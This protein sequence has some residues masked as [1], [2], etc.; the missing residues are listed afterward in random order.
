[1]TPERYEKIGELYHAALELEPAERAAFLAEACGDDELRDEVTCLLASHERADTFIE[2][3]PD[4][5]A[6]GWQA[7]AALQPQSTF[8]HYKLSSLLGKGGM[9]VVWLAEDTRLGRRVAI[10][11][12]PHE[13]TADPE[14]VR[15]FA[16][17]ARSASSLNHPNIVTVHE[18]GEA[19]TESGTTHYIAIEY[20]EG[21]TLRQQMTRAPHQQISLSEALDLATQIAAALAAAHEAGIVHRDIKPENVMVRRDGIVKVLDFGLA[22]L[23]QPATSPIDTQLATLAALTDPG[24]LMGTPRYMSPE[25]ARAEAVDARTDIFSLGVIIYEMVTGRIPFSGENAGEALAAI[26]RDE[27]PPLAEYLPHAPL[28]LERIITKALRK[29]RTVRYQTAQ[30]LVTDLKALKQQIEFGTKPAQTR[31]A[32]RRVSMILAATAALVIFSIVGWF[33]FNRQPALHEKDTVLLTDFDNKTG[34][35]VFDGAL[36]QALAIELLRSPFLNLFPEPQVRQQLALMGRAPNERVTAEIAGEICVRS[37]LKALIAGSIAP[38]GSHYVITLE[39]INGQSGDSLARQQVEA[40]SREQVLRALAQA[41][42]QLR[43]KLGESLSSI[44]KSEQ[45][46]TIATTS[47]LEAFKAWSRGV[48]NSYSGRMMEAISF[49]RRA[50]ELDPEFAQAYSILATIY[51][52]TGRPG[53]AAEYAKKGYELRD[54]VSESEKLLITNF[55]YAF[56]IGDLSKK[57]EVLKLITNSNPRDWSGPL[58][59][60]HTYRQ[61]GQLE[62]SVTQAHEAIRRNPYFAGSHRALVLALF[63]LNHFA[64][65]KDSIAQALQQRINHTDFHYVLYQIAFAEG[66]QAS[67]QEQIDWLSG[68]PDEYL[69][70]D[71]QSGSAAFAG[72]WRKCE[73]SAG[74]AIGLTAHGDTIEIAAR[75]ATEQSIRGAIFGDYRRAKEEAAKGLELARGRASLPRAALALA[76]CGEVSQA[77]LLVDETIKLY[78]DDTVINA[79]WVPVIRAAIELQRGNASRAIELLQPASRYE[80]AA[81]YWPQYLRGSSYVKLGRGA[82]AAAEFQKILD[83]RGQGSL[84]PLYPMAYLGLARAWG[85][86][87]D[88]SR[89]RKASDDFFALWKDADPDLRVLIDAKKEYENR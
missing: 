89:S 79:I 45:P 62:Q 40:E 33:F 47:R 46:L 80:S 48:E 12:L 10:K 56:A 69:G 53:L 73:A 68:K 5:V 7:A 32:A 3:S 9:G 18:I 71:W 25:Q 81:E 43:E 35:E 55:Y 31:Q 60:A 82:E 84:S 29:D 21:E 88:R 75:Y 39:A 74:R 72:Q 76:L 78:P 58:D 86:A 50:I 83:N 54:R 17:E 20:V 38:L 41:A 59:L 64:E 61:I 63:Q 57:I 30:D 26:L 34:D 23:T 49:Y 8:A 85:A 66:D 77:R 52:N 28:G 2:Q 42:S 51:G 67:M 1:M 44:Q 22:K 70:S 13:W 15:R 65:A 37:N 87:G 27:P 24:M 14:S 11:L 6:A 4:D 16:Q 36:K 19:A